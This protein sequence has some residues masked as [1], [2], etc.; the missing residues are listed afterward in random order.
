[1][2]SIYILFILICMNILIY[3][4]DNLY[5]N[6]VNSLEDL[7]NIDTYGFKAKN[8]IEDL[9]YL[10]NQGSLAI[11]DRILDFSIKG[12]GFFKVINEN[13]NVIYY[14]RD[15]SFSLNNEGYLVNDRGYVLYPKIQFNQKKIDKMY[16]E[17][18]RTIIVPD[19]KNTVKY[20]FKLFLPDEK[21]QVIRNGKLFKFEKTVEFN[22]IYIINKTLEMS[23]T[24]IESVIIKMIFIL[25]S[26]DNTGD[27]KISELKTK[28]VIAD[29]L[30]DAVNHW[31]ISI[32]QEN[33]FLE[34]KLLLSK[35][36]S[37]KN[38]SYEQLKHIV[39]SFLPFLE[40]DYQ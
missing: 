27:K 24:D 33:V 40:P 13:E 23:T 22:E 15:G 2:K 4:N 6:Y 39:G 7:K 21:T 37:Q 12:K 3:S 18:S 32:S 30:F 20:E 34:I 31:N 35:E 8:S 1:M 10:Y 14:T 5:N 11:T 28:V 38:R 29:K 26:L 17:N 9:N 19:G 25:N 16:M 36:G